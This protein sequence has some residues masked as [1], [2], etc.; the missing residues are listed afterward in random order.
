MNLRLKKIKLIR[1]KRPST[2]RAF[3]KKQKIIKP[4]NNVIIILIYKFLSKEILGPP[5]IL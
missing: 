2:I 3:I 1:L 5:I 4:D